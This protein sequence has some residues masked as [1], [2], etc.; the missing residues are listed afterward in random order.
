MKT[1]N[2]S[3]KKTFLKFLAMIG[4]SG[5]VGGIVS[6]F[7]QMQEKKISD[8]LKD[9]ELFVSKNAIYIEA[10]VFVLCTILAIFFY[11]RA[12][13]LWKH[14]DLNEEAVFEKID[15]NLSIGIGVVGVSTPLLMIFFGLITTGIQENSAIVGGNI[16]FFLAGVALNLY[17]E[18]LFVNKT[19]QLYPEKKG[20]IFDGRFQKDWMDSSDEAEKLMTYKAAY[21]TYRKMQFLFIGVIVFILM[22]SIIMR[23][24][25][26]VF[27]V[28]AV[29]WIG[30]IMVYV[31]E[32]I[33]VSKEK[34]TN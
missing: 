12:K 4:L 11:Q 21:E 9:V 13:Y 16:V 8:L 5:L 29:L 1:K 6:V 17:L 24:S 10:L 23:I 19:K 15:W 3:E 18:W 26:S 25:L 30:S 20:S 22:L 33:K 7:A 2:K 31:Y 28:I 34:L 32:S 14:G 27:F